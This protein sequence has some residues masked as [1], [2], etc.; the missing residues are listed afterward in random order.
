M[1]KSFVR[2]INLCVHAQSLS[3]VQLFATHGMQPTRLLCPCNSPS[4]Q[5]SRQDYWS[6]LP[7]PSPGDL[8]S[9]G[10]EPASRVSPVLAGRFFI[11]EAPRR[12]LLISKSQI[13]F[14]NNFVFM[15]FVVFFSYKN[16]TSLNI[17]I[18]IFSLTVSSIPSWLKN[19]PLHTLCTLSPTI[20]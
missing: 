12:P 14:P 20:L 10:M 18:F 11:T 8:P 1:C 5:F 19:S 3:H 4:M 16:F 17:K 7:F 9:P 2:V 13:S 6:G 15:A